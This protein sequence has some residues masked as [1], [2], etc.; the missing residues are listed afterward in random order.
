MKRG[1]IWYANLDP[2]KGSEADKTRPVVIVSRDVNNQAAT[3]LGAG[4]VTVVPMTSN[5]SRV[6]SFEVL[7]PPSE[8]GLRLASKAQ[9]TQ[10]RAVD[11][12]RLVEHAGELSGGG[13]AQLDEALRLHLAL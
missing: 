10:I 1:E 9:A 4:V 12:S 11:V 13:L 3:E 6:Y 8:T 5:T 2:T 7:C